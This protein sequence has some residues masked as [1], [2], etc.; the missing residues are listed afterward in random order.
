[1]HAVRL[2]AASFQGTREGETRH[3]EALTTGSTAMSYLGGDAEPQGVRWRTRFLCPLSHDSGGSPIL[4]Q[5]R[6]DLEAAP[7][8]P[9]RRK[10]PPPIPSSSALLDV[11]HGDDFLRTM[12]TVRGLGLT[13]LEDYRLLLDAGGP[14]P[15][16]RGHAPRRRVVG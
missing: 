15:F 13:W 7:L 2:Q 10:H 14:E 8:N 9:H 11:S 16:T 3:E 6:P 1:M 12:R 5:R 4:W